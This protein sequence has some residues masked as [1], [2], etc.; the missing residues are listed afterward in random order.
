MTGVTVSAQSSTA[1]ITSQTRVDR[2]RDDD[3]NWGWIGLLGHSVWRDSSP[4]NA[5]STSITFATTRATD[6]NKTSALLGM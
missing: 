1:N 5:S 4:R 6:G 2:D 3:T